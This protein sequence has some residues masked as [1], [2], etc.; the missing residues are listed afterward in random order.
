MAV[1]PNEGVQYGYS[2][3]AWAAMS[4]RLQANIRSLNAAG[5]SAVNTVPGGVSL[6]SQPAAPAAP[7]YMAPDSAA[8]YAAPVTRPLASA[9][10][11]LAY[12]SALGLEE[13]QARADTDRMRSMYQSEAARQKQ[14]LIP[15]YG[16]ARRNI[17][18]GMEARGM[19]RSGEMLR[20]LAENRAQQGRQ[21]AGIEAGLA[22]QIGQL[23]SNLAQRL[24]SLAS[25]RAQQ[26]LSLRSQGYV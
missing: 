13:S 12:L 26:E 10:E 14:D 9:P 16:Q 7:D 1:D 3:E 25:Q 2:P 18:G 20:R 15:Q 19:A 8:S 6:T 24:G 5:Y 4:P 22:G 21:T 11:W 23:E 17:A